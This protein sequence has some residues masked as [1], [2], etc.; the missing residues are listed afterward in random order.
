[1]FHV[2]IFTETDTRNIKSVKR[3]CGY[4]LEFKKKNGDIITREQFWEEEGT[5]N[6]SIIRIVIKALEKLKDG[7]EVDIYTSNDYV[8]QSV[9]T[10]LEEWKANGFHNKK[11][12]PIKNKEEWERLANAMEKHVSTLKTVA[13]HEY[14]N[15][16]RD[17]MKGQA[18]DVDVAK[19][20]KEEKK[21]KT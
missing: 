9:S 3:G 17:Q 6:Q 15:W 1:M 12:Q 19:T 7:C 4:V 14:S 18:K 13:S 5:Y 10:Y 21:E 8:N 16:M 2:D 20:R 11:G